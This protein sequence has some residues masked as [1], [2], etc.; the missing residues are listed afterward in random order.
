MHDTYEELQ[1]KVKLLEELLAAQ[2][3][4]RDLLVKKDATTRLANA[5]NYALDLCQ[6]PIDR[7][8]PIGIARLIETL[9]AEE[10]R[11]AG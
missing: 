4:E 11:Q 9:G 10:E 6:V 8:T 1:A 5:A 3:A 7:R 2:E